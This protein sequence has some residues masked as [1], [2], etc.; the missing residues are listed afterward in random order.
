M[1]QKLSPHERRE[2]QTI[3]EPGRYRLRARGV[4][5]GLTVLVQNDGQPAAIA[6]V[7]A[8]GWS[9]SE[10]LLQ[11]SSTLRLR[12]ETG[13]ELLF[14]LE[15]MAWTDLAT[16][17]SEVLA[18]QLFRDLFSE[19]S[20]RP[21]EQVSVGSLCILFTDL[22]DSTRMYR[23]IGDA[24]A[25]GRVM[26]HFDVLRDAIDREQ[27]ALVKTIGDAV[28][29][30]FTRPACAVRAIRDAHDRLSKARSVDHPLVLKAG[31]HYG[32]CIAVTLNGRLDY[33]GSTV[34]LASRLQALSTGNDLILSEAVR[35]D[36]EVAELITGESMEPI[37]TALK[38]FDE[39]SFELWR[40]ASVHDAANASP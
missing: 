26:S 27:G 12:N 39:E 11:P 38:G 24:S 36:P 20:L 33:F 17:A 23:A 9:Q 14:M 25:F 5:G 7:S 16:T 32:P 8:E 22:R 1:Q 13:G 19:E 34:N 21:G 37:R 40:L 35:S 2:I 31:I 18:M 15:R 28:M 10:L 3:L 4:S 29:A 6:A 30:V